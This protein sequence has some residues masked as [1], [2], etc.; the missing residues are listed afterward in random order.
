LETACTLSRVHACRRAMPRRTPC[1][2]TCRL[3]LD[4]LSTARRAQTLPS[5]AVSTAYQADGGV[6]KSPEIFD[7]DLEKRLLAKHR[8]PLVGARCRMHQRVPPFSLFWRISARSFIDSCIG[9]CSTASAILGYSKILSRSCFYLTFPSS[10][11]RGSFPSGPASTSRGQR[12]IRGPPLSRSGSPQRSEYTARP[13][14]ALYTRKI[15]P[16]DSAASATAFSERAFVF[17]VDLM[18]TP[19]CFRTIC[20]C[21]AVIL[22]PV[23][24]LVT[25]P[26]WIVL[27]RSDRAGADIRDRSSTDGWPNAASSARAVALRTHLFGQD[28]RGI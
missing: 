10:F 26:G 5:S 19:I 22:P 13:Q 7:L 27:C 8:S 6:D 9:G 3:R 25:R 28:G 17:R 23:R 14:P 4:P 20:P 1:R 11:L 2:R 24:R 15:E 12:S 21:R 16:I 18:R